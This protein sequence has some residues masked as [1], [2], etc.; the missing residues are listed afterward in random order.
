MFNYA[1]INKKNLSLGFFSQQWKNITHMFGGSPQPEPETLIGEWRKIRWGQQEEDLQFM[2]DYQ[3]YNK[4]VKQ[5]R[6][7]LH[8]PIGSGKSSFI[9]SV[10]SALRGKVTGR[11]LTDTISG[12]SF[13]IKRHTYKINNGPGTFYPFVFT[14]LMGIE[15]SETQG[16]CV[17]DIKLEMKGHIKDGYTF[18]PCSEIKEDDP[19]YNKS[20]TLED[21][22]HVLVCVIDASTRSILNTECIR[23]MRQVR[24]AARD[25]G[26][27]QLAVLTKIDKACPEV[28]S[29]VKNVYK[30]KYIKETVDKVSAE[31]GFPP[32]GIFLVR[33]YDSDIEKNDEINT[34]ILS[35]LKRIIDS[36]ED[37]VN[38]P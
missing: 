13:T 21:R 16:V 1:T 19:N 9:N 7:L 25:L 4:E 37:F 6:V 10:E 2:K 11:A 3:P 28:D 38:N 36:G 12:E 18:N 5:L 30:S 15:G 34:L 35:A 32:R 23:K 17:E 22:V 14:D 8:G 31:L 24:L 27:P 33:N 26:I 20:P 29:D